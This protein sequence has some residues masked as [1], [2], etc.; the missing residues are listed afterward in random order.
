MKPPRLRDQLWS[1]YKMGGLPSAVHS[2]FRNV[3][4]A[5]QMAYIRQMMKQQ[6]RHGSLDESL[7][8]LEVVVFDLETTGFYAHQGD[9]IISC[10]AVVV[11]GQC[12]MKQHTFYS[13]CKPD[14][15]IPESIEQLTGIRNEDV[16]DAP[17]V[18][19][20]LQQF[21]TFVGNRMLVAHASAHDKKFLNEALWR[22]SKVQLAHRVLDTLLIGKWLFP[23]ETDHSLD[24]YVERFGVPLLRRHHALD[25]AMM[26]A[27]ILLSQLRQAQQRNVHTIGDLY[28]YLSRT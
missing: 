21:F 16:V 15:G 8:E 18:M 11:R 7:S 1:I 10:G 12:V 27:D 13:L 22:T 26:T 28:A 9:E 19:S 2:V 20:M 25:D 17:D 3:Q 5:Q 23:E 4:S 6:S 14:R 24:R